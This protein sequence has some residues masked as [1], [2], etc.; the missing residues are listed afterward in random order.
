MTR[1]RILCA[2]FFLLAFATSLFAQDTKFPPQGEQI[3]GPDQ[4][5]TGQCCYRGDA[6]KESAEAFQAWIEDVTHWRRE[7]L[8][9]HRL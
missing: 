7:R 8:D 5:A 1:I 4:A 3:P 2:A 9:S 6:T